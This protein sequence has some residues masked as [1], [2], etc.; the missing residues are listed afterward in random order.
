MDAMPK[1]PSI[2]DVARQAGVSYQ[3]VSR[4]INDKGEVSPETR[5]RVLSAIETLKYR[6]SLAAQ[7]FARDRTRIIGVVIPW[8]AEFLSVNHHLLQLILGADLEASVRDYS[9][10]IS[11]ARSSA[12]KASSYERLLHRHI[13][14]GVI[15]EGGIGQMGAKMLLDKGHRVVMIGRNTLGIPFVDSDADEAMYSGTQHLL[16]LG[17]RRIGVISGPTEGWEGRHRMQGCLNALRDSGLNVDQG[18][19]LDSEFSIEGGSKA[20]Q[21]LMEQSDPPTAIFAANDDVAMGVMRW[22][23]E[24]GYRVPEDISVLGFDDTPGA[25]YSQPPLTTIH[26]FS[27]EIGRRAASL[28][29]DLID[30]RALAATEIIQPTRLII[31]GSTDVAPPKR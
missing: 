19:L 6:P 27:N 4:V 17:H 12:D 8:G 2:K 16:A 5:E 21:R 1:R 11:A 18:L 31:R 20:A 29:F 25:Q 26:Q 10:L 13:V 28:L 15:V 3:T 24:N 9:V 30:G 14:D 22:L 23:Q 7:V